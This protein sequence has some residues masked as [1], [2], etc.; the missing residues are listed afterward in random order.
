[1]RKL[2]V[3]AA[4]VAAATTA[5]AQNTAQAWQFRTDTCKLVGMRASNA[6]KY[7]ETHDAYPMHTISD[8]AIKVM[9][10]WAVNYAMTE[11]ATREDA[12]RVSVAKCFDNVDRI[13]SDDR[14]GHRTTE[15][16][17]Q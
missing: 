17:L 7:R 5:Q 4:I 10:V 8:S 9:H 13:Y 6:W 11:A 1:M 3:L 16:E 2:I 15:A 12:I 14:G